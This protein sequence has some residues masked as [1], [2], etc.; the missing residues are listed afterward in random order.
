MAE[1]EE[2]HNYVEQAVQIPRA[3]L[4]C[5]GSLSTSFSLQH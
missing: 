1:I 5:T 2:H 4:R 3:I